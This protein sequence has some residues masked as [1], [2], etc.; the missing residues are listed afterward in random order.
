MSTGTAQALATDHEIE[1]GDHVVRLAYTHGHATVDAVWGHPS[2]AEL[3]EQRTDPGVLAAGDR[4]HVPDAPPRVFEDMP[5]RREHR[6]V[7]ELPVPTLRLALERPGGIPYATPCIA[8]LDDERVRISSDGDGE[9]ALELGPFTTAVALAFDRQALDLAIAQLEPVETTRGWHA[10]LENLGYQPGP[11]HR[12]EPSD[13]YAARSAVEE[14][15][16]DH[17]LTVDGVIGPHTRAA[18]V[19]VHG[20]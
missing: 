15:Q 7:I 8:D 14:F 1:L 18:L 6:I 17:G 5:T 16:C 11:L 12:G 4:V 3:R 9:L 19:R 2:N 10:R 13:P 20:A